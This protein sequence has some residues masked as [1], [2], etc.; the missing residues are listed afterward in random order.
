M[1]LP[2][3]GVGQ[4]WTAAAKRSGDAAFPLA[5]PFH[6]DLPSSVRQA[7]WANDAT[8]FARNKAASRCACRRSPNSPSA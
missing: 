3:K 1:N 6:P 8:V 2:P 4:I 7:V 5:S